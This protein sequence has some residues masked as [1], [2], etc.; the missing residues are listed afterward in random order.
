MPTKEEI[1]HFIK[2]RLKHAKT[3]KVAIVLVG[4]PGSGKSTGKSETVSFL[5]KQLTDFVNID[6][7]EIL[8]SLFNN[9]NKCYDDV[10]KINTESFNLAIKKKKNLIFDG[11][12]KSY[13]WY[14]KNVIKKLTKSGYTVHLV[15]VT[16]NVDTVL[17]RIKKRAR[18]TGRDVNEKYTKSVYEALN[19]AIPKYLDLDCSF[20]HAIY[21]FDNSSDHIK[22]IYKT[23]CDKN[24]E[25]MLVCTL[26]NC[27][28]PKMR[29]R[30]TK[31]PHKANKTKKNRK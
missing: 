17:K 12:G 22:L 13:K 24:D 10:A 5:N 2:E 20:A 15:I 16:N 25:K 31:K 14:S 7:D 26:G 19:S 27:K 23:L 29:T 3:G 9:D 28:M 11:T 4:G 21:L 30:K 6:P 8:T 1:D 18:E